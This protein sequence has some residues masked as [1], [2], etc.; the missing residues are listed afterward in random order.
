MSSI[1]GLSRIQGQLSL[2]AVG[3][4]FFISLPLRS[5]LRFVNFCNL[6]LDG[7]RHSQYMNQQLSRQ[8]RPLSVILT[9]LHF[10]FWSLSG[11]FLIASSQM[12]HTKRTR[13]LPA[14][15][16]RHKGQGRALE[17]RFSY[18]STLP[19]MISRSWLS[20]TILALGCLLWRYGFRSNQEQYLSTTQDFGSIERTV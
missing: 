12:S 2:S 1:R 8:K 7:L 19:S 14:K 13:P 11:V 20:A 5:V 6:S 4:I 10:W 15:E 17:T 9:Q 3:S 16:L 18:I